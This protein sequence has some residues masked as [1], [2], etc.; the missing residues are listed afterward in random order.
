MP[1]FGINQPIRF[2]QSQQQRFENLFRRESQRQG[3]T[4]SQSQIAGQLEYAVAVENIKKQV[5][6]ET[7]AKQIFDNALKGKFKEPAHRQVIQDAGV[8]TTIGAFRTGQIARDQQ[9]LQTQAAIGAIGSYAFNTATRILRTESAN[10]A[11]TSGRVIESQ[12]LQRQI[13]GVSRTLGLTTASGAL[14]SGVL[15]GSPLIA[16]GAA[17]SAFNQAYSIYSESERI[18]AQAERGDNNAQYHNI[19][20]GDIVRR[21]NR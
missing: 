3:L 11:I 2:P 14:I 12:R 5:N 18:S 9:L 8:Q 4:K 20:Y 16:I 1:L 10:K 19:V 13:S 17:V 7:V 6:D 21:G 15:S